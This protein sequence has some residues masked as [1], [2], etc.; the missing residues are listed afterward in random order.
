MLSLAGW[1]PVKP[2]HCL[3]FNNALPAMPGAKPKNAIEKP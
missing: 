3:S 1:L 2:K